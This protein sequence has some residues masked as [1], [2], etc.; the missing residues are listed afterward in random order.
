MDPLVAKT[1]KPGEY[2][3]R[4][5]PITDIHLNNKLPAGGSPVSDPKYSYILATVGFLILLIACINFI[6]LSVGRSTTR[7][8]EVG[9]RKTLGAERRQL[10]RQFWGEAMLLTLFAVLIGTGF[11]VLLQK[12]FNQITNRELSLSFDWFTILYCFILAISIALLAGMYPAVV[13]SGFKPIQVLKGRLK[14]STRMGFFGKALVTGQFVAS[15]V[16]I[17]GTLV[18]SRQLEYLMTKD[19]GY[20]KEHI[21]IVPT[22]KSRKDGNKLA[23]IFN[24]TIKKNPEVISSTTSLFS[25]AESGWMNLG[26][27]DDQHV[28]RQFKFNAVDADFIPT[29]GLHVISGRSFSKD[30]P[31]DSNYILVNE[32]LVKEYGWKDP[33]GQRLPGTYSERVLGVV[34]DFNFESLH[35]GIKP[36]VMALRPDSIFRHSSDVS[37]DFLPEPRVSVRFR[38]GDLQ[39]Q[40]SFLRNAWKSVAGDQDFE[41]SFLDDALNNAYQHDQRLS[42]IVTYGSVLSILIACMGLFGLATLV[43]LRRTK[44]IGIRKVLGASVG[45]ILQL[46]SRDFV[47]LILIAIAIASPIA[48]WALHQWLQDFNYRIKIGWWMFGA[49]GCLALSIA[50]V[51]VCIQAMRAALANPVKSLRTE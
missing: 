19:L 29:M 8:L 44:E 27:N 46:L 40:I 10:I 37:Y 5:Q 12:P 3:V 49:A 35:T 34:K 16:L 6:T 50:L 51:T 41:Y 4:L 2:K 47:L 24:N 9:I 30:D 28:F 14:M 23:A 20:N 11:A 21:V 26:Y 32:A 33:I 22:N 18:V 45:S 15:I 7:A 1:Y 25:M 38:G 43:V 48:W 17:T 13:L 39:Q 36:A 42:K 31:A